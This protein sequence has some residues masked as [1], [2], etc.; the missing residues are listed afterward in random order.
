MTMNADDFS[1][2]ELASAYLD[3][4][5][6]PDERVQAAADPAVIARV[7]EFRSLKS[8]LAA[9]M[10]DEQ[11][12][13]AIGADDMIARAMELF[14]E[15]HSDEQHAIVGNDLPTTSSVIAGGRVSPLRGRSLRRSI[16]WSG[17]A[18]A[19]AVLGGVFLVGRLANGPK[20]ES[21]SAS[22]A[23]SA[24]T[25]AAAAADAASQAAP[26][27][28]DAAAVTEAATATDAAPSAFPQSVPVTIDSIGAA[29]AIDSASGGA[30]ATDAPAATDAAAATEAAAPATTVV[31]FTAEEQIRA[32]V[33]ASVGADR[34]RLSVVPPANCQLNGIAV[35]AVTWQGVPGILVLSPDA[36][37]P[38]RAE[39]VDSACT[40]L[41]GITIGT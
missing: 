30:P 24:A 1:L 23:D 26:A 4:E 2:D 33:A 7:G 19:A 11:P 25:T 14:D 29:A 10:T 32:Y 35:E 31:S 27:A 40:V 5:V 39:V 8:V 36:D 38:T 22:V 21:K 12:S 6:T 20:S 41:V 9:D 17:L 34:S 37:A 3:N 15:Q 18:I 28:T 16:P 13:V